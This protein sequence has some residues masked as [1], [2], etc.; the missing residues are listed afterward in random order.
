MTSRE[1]LIVSAYT[2]ILL[3]EYPLF[4]GFAERLLERE[5]PTQEFS[6]QTIWDELKLKVSSQFMEL[7]KTDSEEEVKVES[8]NLYDHTE[9]FH[10]C[11][12][13]VLTNT[14]TGECSIGWWLNEAPP[15]AL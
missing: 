8:M 2:G 14:Q 1:K 11:T 7:S 6:E 9:T 5:I 10:D 13:Q 15:M 3:C 12:V 4:H